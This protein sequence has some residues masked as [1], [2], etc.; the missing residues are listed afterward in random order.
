[1]EAPPRPPA[2]VPSPERAPPDDPGMIA[3]A[4]AVLAKVARM[5]AWDAH[6]SV[7]LWPF[8]ADG[9]QEP[10]A[11]AQ[12]ALLHAS[13]RHAGHVVDPDD[14]RTAAAGIGRGEVPPQTRDLM[15]FGRRTGAA[16]VLAGNIAIERGEDSRIIQVRVTVVNVANG[17]V[18]T[19]SDL[20]ISAAAAP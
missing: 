13:R 8:G 12:S 2:S 6:S 19:Y 17:G 11:E 10:G 14:A 20:S 1:M 9:Q 4:E 18:S 3:R 7:A 5:H 16:F 15:E